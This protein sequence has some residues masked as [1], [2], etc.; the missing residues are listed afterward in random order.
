MRKRAAVI[1]DLVSYGGAALMNIIPILY[2]LGVEVNPIP[3]TVFTTHGGFKGI[4]KQDNTEFMKDYVSHWHELN[5]SFQGIY[6]GLFT[7]ARQIENAHGFLDAFIK[8]DTLTVFDPIMGD[9]GRLYSFMKEIDLEA[10]KSLVKR[11][12][13]ITPNLTEACILLDI[14]YN[15]NMD[16]DEI[17]NCLVELSKLGPQY[18]VITSVPIGDKISTYSY[19]REDELIF[20]V[21]RE[22][23]AGSY[24]GTGDIFTSVLF[25]KMLQGCGIEESLITAI[26]FVERG[27]KLLM[28]RNLNPLEGLPLADTELMGSLYL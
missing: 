27:I 10:M 9:N 12:D 25:A 11:V 4:K 23:I 20:E 16:K 5:L 18:V 15:T 8:E 28:E 19:N 26:N 1:H 7:S 2:R 24:P 3:T 14:P 22:K 13:I 21:S 17:K 6:L